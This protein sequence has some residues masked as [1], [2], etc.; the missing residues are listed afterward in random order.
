MSE[1]LLVPPEVLVDSELLDTVDDAEVEAGASGALEPQ[2]SRVFPQ[3]RQQDTIETIVAAADQRWL[4]LNEGSSN[5]WARRKGVRRVLDH[6]ARVPEV[7]WQQRFEASGLHSMP[8]ADVASTIHGVGAKDSDRNQV[9]AGLST[10]LIMDVI[11]PSFE[12]TL[13]MNQSHIW[14]KMLT[15][16]Q[17]PSAHILDVQSAAPTTRNHAIAALGRILLLTGI[18]AAAVTENDLLTYRQ[19]ALAH[20][21]YVNGIQDLW[22]LLKPLG[23]ITSE[24]TN[25][26]RVGQ[27]SPAELVDRYDVQSPRI[28]GLLVAYLTRRQASGIDYNTVRSLSRVLVKGFWKVVEDIE[29]GIDTLDLSDETRDAFLER[30]RVLTRKDGTE[31]DRTNWQH[32]LMQIRSFYRDLQEW[33]HSEPERW[34]QFA[35][36]VPIEDHHIGDY[37]KYRKHLRNQMH[38]RTRERAPVIARLADAAERQYQEV[39]ALTEAAAANLPGAEFVVA[40]TQYRRHDKGEVGRHLTVVRVDDPDARRIDLVH[41]EEDAF[42]GFAVTET[43]RHTGVRIEELLEFTQLDLID[44]QHEDGQVVLLHVN[45]SKTDEE[46]M[47]VAAPELVAVFAQMMRRIRQAAGTTGQALPSV[48]A[49]DYNEAKELAPMPVLFQRTAG[50]G[51]KNNATRFMTRKYVYEVISQVCEYSGITG[52]DGKPLRFTPHDFRRIF[53]TDALSSGIPPHIIMKLMGH[54]SLATTEHYMA[55]FPQDVI[56]AHRTFVEERRSLRREDYRPVEAD[57][58]DEFNEHFGKRQIAIGQCVRAFG[59]DCVHEYACEQ[60]NLAR[61]SEEARPRLLRTHESLL[62]QLQ[63][64]KDRR[65]RGEIERLT[66]IITA[67]EGKIDDLDRAARRIATV[68]L[69]TPRLRPSEPS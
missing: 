35:V 7:T 10:L 45:P 15:H 68:M 23:T 58:W 36:R 57:E 64:A 53:A 39:L 65:W 9:T 31:S 3:S 18:N 40:E 28:R 4:L 8:W 66:H 2:W 21:P 62:E 17:D 29:P 34:A 69:P 24:W 22:G 25:P 55:I 41:L 11:R 33:A 14:T 43:L 38:Q 56:R 5:R 52:N 12:A 13:N 20:R 30:H 6:L 27:Q 16:R 1:D 37:S 60:C 59:T 44:H 19:A 47:L 32:E 48:P 42:W 54:N 49:W 50:R 51:L 63:E 26:R 46:R 61:P 67:I